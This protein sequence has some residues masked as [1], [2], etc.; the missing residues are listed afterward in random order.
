MGAKGSKQKTGA[1]RAIPSG[2]P[3][4][5]PAQEVITDV[6]IKTIIKEVIVEVIRLVE[7]PAE[8]PFEDMFLVILV[9]VSDELFPGGVG[10]WSIQ[11]RTRAFQ[12]IMDRIRTELSVF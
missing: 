5:L 9:I 12:R 7:V 2:R 11:D 4:F 6:Q 3:T 1:Q 10:T 8:F